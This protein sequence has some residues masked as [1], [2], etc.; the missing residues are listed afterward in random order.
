MQAH[1]VMTPQVIA[2][3]PDTDV[4][5]I[6]KL[7]VEHRI[8]AV[9]VVDKSGKVVGIVS[10]GDLMRRAESGTERHTSWWLSL[11][12]QPE[13]QTHAYVKTHGH[14]A[15]DVMTDRVITVEENTSLEHVADLLEKNRIKRV[16]VLRDGKMVGIVSRA[17]LLHGLV[18]RQ[19]GQTPSADDR[20]IKQAILKGLRDGA[21]PQTLLSVV[22]TSGVVHVWGVV[23][24]EEQREAVRIAVEEAPGVK[25]VEFGVNVMPRGA[26][27]VMVE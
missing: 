17:D 14:R 27:T 1:D 18:A 11:F 26:R 23:E 5:E 16:P 7:L 3:E 2:V 19:A 12:L 22:V 10:E 15:A 4:R 21:I 6:A 8:S 20:T 9:P 13:D 25:Q 24:T